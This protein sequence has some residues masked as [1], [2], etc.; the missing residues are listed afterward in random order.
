MQQLERA[1][2]Q[3]QQI[4]NDFLLDKATLKFIRIE[5]QVFDL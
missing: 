5:G 1:P 2:L 4:K 3:M